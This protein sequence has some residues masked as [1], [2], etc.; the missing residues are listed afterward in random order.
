M[1]QAKL[2][3]IAVL[4]VLTI[5]V[6]LQNTEEVDTRILF[7]T[8]TMPRALLLLVTFLIGAVSGMAVAAWWHRRK[9]R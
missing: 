4:I 2:V 5:V 6:I 1:K 8:V 7:V 9:K 3:I